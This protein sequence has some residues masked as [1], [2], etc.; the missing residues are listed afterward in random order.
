[1]REIKHKYTFD[2]EVAPDREVLMS[3]EDGYQVNILDPVTLEK[4]RVNDN[5]VVVN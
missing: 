1:M 3:N 5:T 4:M 2:I